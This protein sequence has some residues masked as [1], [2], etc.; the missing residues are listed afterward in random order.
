M[1]EASLDQHVLDSLLD[2]VGGDRYFLNDLIAT[3]LQDAPLLRR[4]YRSYLPLFPLAIE[5]LE[6]FGFDL[7][8]STSHCVAKGARARP[9]A[10]HVCYCHTPMRY[11][12]DQRDAYFPDRSGCATTPSTSSTVNSDTGGSA[13]S[14]RPA[15]VSSTS[16]PRCSDSNSTSRARLRALLRADI[17]GPGS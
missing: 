16:T 8:V 6:L 5:Q 10:P 2:A 15:S 14:T 3:F 13:A 1:S 17:S 7:V 4:R 12:W 11:A 9:G